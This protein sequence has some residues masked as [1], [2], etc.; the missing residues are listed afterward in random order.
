ME[1][2][3]PAAL[4]AG[5]TRSDYIR[6][7]I[8]I[9]IRLEGIGIRSAAPAPARDPL[10]AAEC[11]PDGAPEGS[12]DPAAGPLPGR[13]AAATS[14][15]SP[16]PAEAPRQTGEQVVMVTARGLESLRVAIDRWG[17]NYNQG[18]RAINTVASRFVYVRSLHPD[19][20]EEIMML[21]RS[22]ARS[23]EL[24]WRGIRRVHDDIG[25]YLG[26]AVADIGD[27]GFTWHK[28]AGKGAADA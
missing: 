20:Y 6:V 15:T 17:V 12:L 10:G 24:S 27:Y 4:A 2:L 16:A 22:C 21:L 28:R 1:K 23:C 26:G 3:D 14:A 9:P 25:E 8:S 7:L 13:A 18:V 11:G 5:L 19:E